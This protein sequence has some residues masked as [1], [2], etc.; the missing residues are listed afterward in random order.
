MG[1]VFHVRSLLEM[2]YVAPHLYTPTHI[3]T[4][5]FY[6][7]FLWPVC[8]FMIHVVSSINVSL[9]THYIPFLHLPTQLPKLY[10]L[11]HNIQYLGHISFYSASLDL[12]SVLMVPFISL[13]H[14]LNLSHQSDVASLI[15]THVPN[16]HPSSVRATLKH[17]ILSWIAISQSW[18]LWTECLCP[19]VIHQL[20]L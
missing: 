6:T 15:H 11:S 2:Q 4:H 17:S 1:L 13:E 5:S 12:V 20:K 19:P 18:L 8:F 14:L 3:Y 7:S 9:K 16:L 10:L